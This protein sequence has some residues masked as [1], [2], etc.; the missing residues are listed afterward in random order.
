M[1]F[2]STSYGVHAK[3]K[4]STLGT[5]QLLFSLSAATIHAP[6]MERKIIELWITER[7]RQVKEEKHLEFMWVFASFTIRKLVE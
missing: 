4:D 3:G 1:N 7:A 5:F 6:P 2:Q